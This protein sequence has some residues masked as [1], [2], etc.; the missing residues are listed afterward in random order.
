MGN[1]ISILSM[2]REHDSL[3]EQAF[4]DKFIKPLDPVHL[5]NKDD[6]TV[7]YHV[8]VKGKEGNEYK[9]NVLWSCHIDT[10]HRG[11][12]DVLTQEV[13]VDEMGT[14]FVSDKDDCL[15]ADDGAGAW[16][17]LE[18]IK[19]G[20]RGTYIFHRGEEKGCWG[21]KQVATLHTGW[22]AQYTHAIA[23]DRR[24]THSII[25]HQQSERG[26]SDVLGNQLIEL[27]NLGHELDDTGV[28]TDTAEYMD[29]VPECVNISIGY[30]S[31]HSHRETLDTSY[32]FKMR[33]AICALDWD[34]IDLLVERDP[35][36]HEY[37]DY[38]YG[39]GYSKYGVGGYDYGLDKKSTKFDSYYYPTVEE[40][41]AM[42][43]SSITD[44]VLDAEPEEL[45]W[46]MNDLINRINEL[47][48][49]LE[50]ML[51]HNDKEEDEH[52]LNVG[53]Q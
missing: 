24:A 36:K 3:G 5:L 29:I 48:Y 41:C 32:L 2:R 33:D 9:S 21:S 7:A 14:A 50:L 37:K 12:P 51:Q 17:M 13:W 53:M 52:Y 19:A 34:N 25:T 38:G 31:E 49:D 45:A 27:F 30:D 28:Y 4:I 39:Y 42:P 23:F 26:C 11:K 40:L 1:L 8:T 47:E 20:V 43:S 15:G 18:M 44:Y 10:M 35:S 16:L 46:T 6:V 22:L